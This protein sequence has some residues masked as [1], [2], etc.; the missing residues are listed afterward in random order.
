MRDLNIQYRS[1]NS[2]RPH[3]R[4]ARTHSAK[5]I[6]Q[7][8]DSI[9]AFGF[10][11]PILIDGE[12]KIIAGHGRVEA[13]KILGLSTVPTIRLKHLSEAEIRAYVI[14]DNRLAERAGW[15]NEL[16][17]LELQY[18]TELDL[19]LD[20]SITGFETPEIDC[21]IEGLSDDAE[22]PAADHVPEVDTQS[23]ATSRVGDLWLLGPHRLLCGDA[24]DATCFG[25]LM[26][27]KQAEMVFCD[28]PYNVPIDGHVCGLGAIRHENFVMASGEM[29][30]EEYG[31][32]LKT[33]LGQ[34]ACHTT[35]GSIHYICIDWRHLYELLTAGRAVY[36]ELKNLCV[37]AK[38]NGGMGSFYRSQHELVCVFKS[39]SAPHLNN[40]ELGRYGRNRTN[41]WH[42]DGVNSLR[43]G[44]LEELRMHPTVKPVAMV[45]DAILD[46]SRRHGIVIDCFAGSGTTI[47]AADKTGRRANAMELHPRYIDTAV[48][49]WQAL[50]GKAAILDGTELTFEQMVRTRQSEDASDAASDKAG[51]DKE[52]TQREV[53]SDV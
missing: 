27:G 50:T 52:P 12:G 22:D 8:A 18:L 33:V 34:L 14:A 41:V 49:R 15:D 36:S 6:R 51:T 47:I 28:P 4:N 9:K 3:D 20:V 5:Q 37:W 23:A 11:N 48:R 29:S 31:H 1:V 35:D 53:R 39:G 13:A 43:A 25:R 32:F 24:L 42:Y 44:R 10:T 2:L 21:L 46:C 17:A 19:E 40:V 38:P 45:S 7:I 26:G 30:E 16:L